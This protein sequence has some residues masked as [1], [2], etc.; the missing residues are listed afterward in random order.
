M[1]P[2]RLDYER[3][4]A[5]H[6]AVAERL[7]RDPSIVER[8]RAKLEEWIARGG[9]STEILVQWRDVLARPVDDIARF[10]AERSEHA[11]WLRSASPFAGAL[12]PPTRLAILRAVRRG[13]SS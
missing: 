9:R 1:Q 6:A 5:L 8:A 7:R 4:L 11:A 12:D 2:A 3:S 13:R 10:L